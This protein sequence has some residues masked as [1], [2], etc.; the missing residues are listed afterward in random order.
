MENNK[1]SSVEAIYPLSYMQQGLLL[2]HLSSKIDQGF[3]NTEC[4]LTGDFNIEIFKQSC[5]LIIKRHDILRSTVHWKNL[6]KPLLV[7]HKLKKIKIEYFDWTALLQTEKHTHWEAL[8]NNTLKIG[9]PLET[10]ALLKISILKLTDKTHKLLWPMHHILLDGWSGSNII[11]DLFKIYEALHEGESPLLDKL[12][13]YKAYL[14]WVNNLPNTPAKSFWKNY[15]NDY[16][17]TN[18]F[19]KI[20]VN[21]FDENPITNRFKLSKNESITIKVYCK[22]N[23]ITT[24]TL[25]QSI[26]SLVLTKYFKTTDVIHGTTVSGRSSDFPNINLLTGMFMNVQPVRGKIDY[27][28]S[29]SSWFQE[30]QNFHFEA[31]KYEYLSLDKLYSFI[32]WSE[33]T[34]LFDSLLVFEN[35]PIAN[36]KKSILQISDAKSGLTSTYP[37]TLSIH[38]SVEIEFNLT[39]LPKHINNRLALWLLDTFKNI[40]ELV[41][42]EQ[43]LNYATLNNKINDFIDLNF[44]DSNDENKIRTTLYQAPKNKTELELLKIWGDVLGITQIGIND[45]FFEIG[46]KSLVAIKMFSKINGKFKT[47]LPATQLIEYPTISKLSSYLLSGSEPIPWNYI[48]PIKTKGNKNP[49]FCI[50]AGGGHVFFYGWLKDYLKKGRPIYALEPSGLNQ[51]ESMHENVETM[52]RDYLKDIQEIQPKG[53]YNILVYCFSTTV[54]N[55]MSILL[56]KAGEEVNIIVIDTLASS[57][58]GVGDVNVKARTKFFFKRLAASPIK[59]IGTF[60]YERSYL[61]KPLVVKLFGQEHE[62]KLEKVRANLRKM[63]I[64]YKYKPHNGS[65]SLIL[66]HKE[67]KKFEDYIIDSWTKLAK[68]GV[69][70]YYTKGNHFTLFEKPDIEYISEQIDLTLK[71]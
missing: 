13:N 35:Y 26:W 17:T 19:S 9:A 3:L 20:S 11:N 53:P 44:N 71:D 33:N 8:K 67:D 25:I 41:T 12:P 21:N 40:L 22:N 37:I 47:K 31:R 68:G 6:E 7:I 15:L 45:N 70:V 63:S 59:T 42:T 60:I 14:N 38:P 32:N 56:E 34:S 18:L 50:H 36:S 57:W 28:Q 65:V 43:T 64:D 1:K 39:T 52:A 62:K 69:D 55:E 61:V 4:T 48:V 10:G 23:K 49:L 2:H 27:N 24:N 46:G 29:F 66:T 5:E 58:G 51:D 54:G 16:N 30:M